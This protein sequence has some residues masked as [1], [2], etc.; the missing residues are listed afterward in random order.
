MMPP[1]A[2]HASATVRLGGHDFLADRSGALIWPAAA[3]LLVADLHLE[4]GSAFAGRGVLLPPYDSRQT[5]INLEVAVARHRPR[6]IICLGD[7]FHDRGGPQRLPADDRRRLQALIAAHDWLWITGNHDENAAGVLGGEVARSVIEQGVALRHEA[8]GA[9]EPGE[10]LEISGHF[11]PKAI[12]RVRGR[13]LS[14]RCFAAGT[15]D[16]VP[17]GDGLGPVGLARD[18]KERA[19]LILPAFGAYTG[20]L[21]V[22]DPAIRPLF[23][24]GFEAWMLGTDGV[25]RLPSTRLDPDV[26]RQTNRH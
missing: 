5:L 23:R 10:R 9:A 3:A 2:P 7:S 20:G 16:A 18:G 21:N 11:H 15:A 1:I 14:R 12:I 17:G 6:R 25:H 26:Q 22:L 4:K 19:R 13:R 8:S 24:G